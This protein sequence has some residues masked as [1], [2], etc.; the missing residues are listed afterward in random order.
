MQRNDLSLDMDLFPVPRY[1]CHVTSKDL[2]VRMC[3][4]A[5]FMS[6]G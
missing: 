6:C 5:F 1:V 2:H 4:L 3:S